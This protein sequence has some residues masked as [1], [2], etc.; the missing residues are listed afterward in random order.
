MKHEMEVWKSEGRKEIAADKAEYIKKL[1]AAELA[2][3][4]IKS[5][6]VRAA[7]ETLRVQ[8]KA[9]KHEME[10]WK[11]D[12]RKQIIAD[13]VARLKEY[14]RV[15]LEEARVKS[16]QYRFAQEAK[17]VRDKA[18]KHEMNVWKSEGRK[19]FA[20]AVA[21]DLKRLE[22][23][24]LKESKIKSEQINAARAVRAAEEKAM[25][26]EMEVWKSDGRK[27]I[28]IEKAKD[29]ARLQ[30]EALEEARIKS[31]QLRAARAIRAAEEKAMKHEIKVWQSEGRKAIAVDK[32]ADLARLEEAE[33]A[34]SQI[35]SEQIYAARVAKAAAE[36]A[37]K[38]EMEVW[39]SEGRKEIAADRAEYLKK[40]EAEELVESRMKSEQI[41]AARKVRAAEEKA[42][43]HELK[44]WQS[45]GRKAFAEDK[46]VDLARLQ[47]A[48]LE[49]S[50]IKSEQLRTARATKAAAEKAMK[51]EMEV[52]KSEG[53]KEIAADKAE[54]LKKLEA[55]ELVESRIKSEQI[56]AA[57]VAKAAKEK[58]MKHEME[59][60]KSEGR[61]DFAIEKA[62]DL[63]RL[64]AAELEE[65]RIKSE[66]MRAAIA[67]RK[68]HEKSMKHEM[69]VWKS[70][71]R[72]EAEIHKQKELRR[73]EAE[74]IE[75][76]RIK[77]ENVR[78][79]K[80]NRKALEKAMKHEM[81]VWKSDG[82][83]EIAIDKAEY[84]KKLEIAELEE[85]KI[86]SDQIRAA[87]ATKA[88]A[89]KAMKHEM[90]VWKSEGRKEIAADKAEYLKKLEAAELEESRIKSDQIRAARAVEAAEVKAMKHEQ[91]V[92][93]SEGRKQTAIEKAEYLKR[94]EAEELI[95][96]KKKSEQINAARVKR[97]VDEKAV[98][99]ERRA[100]YLQGVK[101][102]KRTKEEQ[103][104]LAQEA[105]HLSSYAGLMNP[106]SWDLGGQSSY[107]AFSGGSGIDDGYD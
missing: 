13:E 29:L 60:W 44:V 34:E 55:A 69:E 82:R 96:S 11:S 62:K 57:R 73:L 79:A 40:L 46:A 36:K 9:M 47:A 74:A 101:E 14:E 45:E 94:L 63:A 20:V 10:V 93:Q 4:R 15:A 81:E 19:D 23:E 5:E 30:A 89:E 61:K 72:K 32:A 59:V 41:N 99:A 87:R 86:K 12:G 26:H 6:Q 97:A 85:S 22:A 16:E 25:K 105:E 66:Q 7:R 92:W 75:E 83:K 102:L 24:E 71:G 80:T 78:A 58:A 54:Y 28:A 98:E 76:A 51:H 68:A 77:S 106:F 53:R 17:R 64:E 50:R 104:R 18:M 70:E 33:L 37:M 3:S 2:E 88:A 35:K 84:L 107:N 91:K 52:W 49:E 67:T 1:E 39:K 100:H 42:M 65:S 21:V 48:E 8:A 43:K 27:E 38:H 90:E 95:E 56:N 103:E 31:E